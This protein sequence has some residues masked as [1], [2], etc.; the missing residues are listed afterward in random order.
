MSQAG[1]TSSMCW[2][3][4]PVAQRI[5]DARG[6]TCLVTNGITATWVITLGVSYAYRCELDDG[7]GRVE[8]MFFG[9]SEVPRIVKGARST[10]EG[11]VRDDRAVLALLN[12]LYTLE[13]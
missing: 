2:G 9:R 5:A 7:T 11:T 3:G 12:P 8:L 6:R 1:L 4:G 13:S 10:V